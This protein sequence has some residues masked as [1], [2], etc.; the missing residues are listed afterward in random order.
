MKA[1]DLVKYSYPREAEDI[2]LGL[3]LL[4]LVDSTLPRDWPRILVLWNDGKRE[5]MHEEDLEV[6]R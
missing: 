1:G 5:S 4:S 2:E 6:I 3:V